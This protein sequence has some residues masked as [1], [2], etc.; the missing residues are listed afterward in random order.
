M[1][2]FKEHWYMTITQLLGDTVHWESLSRNPLVSK[3][4]VKNHPEGDWNWYELS[5][6]LDFLEGSADAFPWDMAGICRNPLVTMEWVIEQQGVQL[7]YIALGQ[8]P[9][10]SV[11]DMIVNHHLPWSWSIVSR[12]SHEIPNAMIIDNIDLPWDFADMCENPNI[13]EVVR[14]FPDRE[15]D[16][17]ALSEHPALT[18]DFVL[19]VYAP[20]GAES[21][22]L[23]WGLLSCHPNITFQEIMF[24]IHLPWK[25]RYVSANPNVTIDTVKN[26]PNYNWNWTRLSDNPS[27][28]LRDVKDNADFPWVME[29]VSMNPSIT[30]DD[31]REDMESE[32]P[33]QWDAQRLSSRADL[34]LVTQ[35]PDL[36]WDW[37]M[38]SS[39]VT[40]SIEF[41]D[42]FSEQNLNWYQ[43]STSPDITLDEVIS[44][45]FLPWCSMGLC[46]NVQTRS[47]NN[48]ALRV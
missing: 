4:L 46:Q 1:N 35:H 39:V 27:M 40:P 15:W 25:A 17:F 6:R 13:L 18:I 20:E 3:A 7:N 24:N 22:E 9:A 12:R 21:P 26:N 33:L 48:Y 47:M 23:A 14:M 32:R 30:N 41:A 36:N 2:E 45:P 29:V 37:Y 28:T 38:V 34:N 10:I 42:M 44:S 43:V 5:R 31:I 8:N 16:W 11:E 19:A